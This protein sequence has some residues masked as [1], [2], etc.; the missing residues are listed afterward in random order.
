[1]G[2][3]TQEVVVSNSSGYALVRLHAEKITAL[4]DD[5]VRDPYNAADLGDRHAVQ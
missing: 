5:A 1:M 3:N 2:D 4:F